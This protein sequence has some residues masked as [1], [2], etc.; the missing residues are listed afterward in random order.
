MRAF[1]IS[2]CPRSR[3]LRSGCSES[4]TR[5]GSDARADSSQ[6]LRDPLLNEFTQEDSTGDSVP[7]TLT[8]E[9]AD[10]S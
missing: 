2:D 4:S 5:Q 10:K 1:S 6:W 9:F 3:A 8:V 7:L